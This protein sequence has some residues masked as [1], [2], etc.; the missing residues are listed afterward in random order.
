MLDISGKDQLFGP[1]ALAWPPGCAQGRTL[2]SGAQD[3]STRL[4]GWC[5]AGVDEICRLRGER[6]GSGIAALGR[7]KAPRRVPARPD[8]PGNAPD[9]GLLPENRARLA[10]TA[11]SAGGEA[12]G[13]A[14]HAW[15]RDGPLGSVGQVWV[16]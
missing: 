15:R 10:C 8:R 1:G 7:C 4:L 14:P 2:V 9:L 3:G 12:V 5:L 11:G 16:G 6:R 13:Q